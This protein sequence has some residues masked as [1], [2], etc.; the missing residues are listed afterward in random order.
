VFTLAGHTKPITNIACSPDGLKVVTGSGDRTAKVWDAHTGKELLTLTGHSSEIQAVAFSADSRQIA[1]GSGDNTAIIWE[2][3]TG[4]ELHTLPGNV[5]TVTGV[6]FDPRDSG[7]LVVASA[8]GIV[9]VLLLNT[10]DQVA[11]AR[12]RI[13]H[14]LTDWECQKFL[15][16]APG[17]CSR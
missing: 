4:K 17:A 8:D 14:T 3:V 13:T 16:R 10:D 6:A 15:H 7:R 2:A 9:R 5:G 1:T 12:S 11:L